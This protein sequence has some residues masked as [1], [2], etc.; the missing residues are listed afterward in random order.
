M[1]N[2]KFIPCIYNCLVTK[3]VKSKEV[4]VM[5]EISKNLSEIVRISGEVY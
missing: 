5:F 2:L 1:K 4:N 3:M